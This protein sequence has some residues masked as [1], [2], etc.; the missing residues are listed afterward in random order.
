MG[1]SVDLK[2]SLDRSP[3]SYASSG[4]SIVKPGSCDTRWYGDVDN[5]KK[6]FSFCYGGIQLDGVATVRGCVT[7]Y[8]IPYGRMD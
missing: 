2:V 6:R 4:T 8:C 1:L 5:Q 3:T 7:L